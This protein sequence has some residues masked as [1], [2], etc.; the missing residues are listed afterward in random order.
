MGDVALSGIL[1]QR[2]ALLSE[3]AQVTTVEASVVGGGS[4]GR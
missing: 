1:L 3:V 4:S 2:G